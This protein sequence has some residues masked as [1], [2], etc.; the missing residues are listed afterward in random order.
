LAQQ[1]ENPR[2]LVA[3]PVYNEVAHA[4]RVLDEVRAFH[5]EILVVDDGSTDGTPELLARRGDVAAGHVR[6]VRHAK[7][8][9]YGQSLITAFTY[10]AQHS[11]D[12]V[13]TMDCDE[14]HEPRRIPAFLEHI[15]AAH[16]CVA[17]PDIVSGTRYTVGEV[18]GDAA[19]ADR[20]AINMTLT[21][22]LNDTLGVAHL[23]T[24]L[25]DSFCGFKAHRVSSLARLNL[26]ETGYA[27]PMQLWPQAALAGLTVE[28]LPV[29]RIYNDPS[30]T[31][32]GQL[33]D[34][35][36]RLRHYVEVLRREIH[37]PAVALTAGNMS[38][39]RVLAGRLEAAIA[40]HI[41][42]LSVPL[43][44]ASDRSSQPAE[45]LC[46]TGSCCCP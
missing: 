19:P 14:Q 1:S 20:K 32:G 7:N 15:A 43:L 44:P 35:E 29:P 23:G 33:D 11:F 9:G 8:A 37:Q 10:A 31:F 3:I 25:T 2:V 28:E 21:A 38:R 34:P 45:N 30:R 4:S 24:R 36:K 12:W 16:N 41:P 6:V 39:Q 5:P 40:R 18:A 22:V 26:T 17:C 27:F 46:D 13:I 42:A